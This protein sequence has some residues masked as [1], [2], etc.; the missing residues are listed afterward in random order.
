MANIRKILG[1]MSFGGQF[2]EAQVSNLVY[3]SCFL[4]VTAFANFLSFLLMNLYT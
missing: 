4:Y 2:N 1:A 3:C